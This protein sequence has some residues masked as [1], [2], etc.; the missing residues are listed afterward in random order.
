MN[1]IYF[2]QFNYSLNNHCRPVPLHYCSICVEIVSFSRHKKKT[3]MKKHVRFD[4]SAESVEADYEYVSDDD[5]DRNDDN[6]QNF[7]YPEPMSTTN[8][9]NTDCTMINSH[10]DYQDQ[11]SKNAKNDVKPISQRSRNTRSRDIT[12]FRKRRDLIEDLHKSRSRR[13]TL[14]RDLHGLMTR[15]TCKLEL[16]SAFNIVVVKDEESKRIVEKSRLF[17]Q[18]VHV[19]EAIRR[20]VESSSEVAS[21]GINDIKAIMD[22]IESD[23]LLV[24]ESQRG[25]FAQ[26]LAEEKRLNQEL[27]VIQ[28]RLSLWDR[29]G[30]L[31]E[32]GQSTKSQ[33]IDGSLTTAT[34]KESDV[35]AEIAAFQDYLVKHGGYYGGWDDLSHH[36][37]LKLRLKHGAKDE[38]FL[39]ACISTIPGIGLNEAA[40][41]EAW[42]KKF[43]LL[44]DAKKSALQ[45]W[46]ERKEAKAGM[47][48]QEIQENQM[49]HSIINQNRNEMEMQDRL[50]KKL[51]VEKWKEE[52]KTK[53]K[54]EEIKQSEIKGKLLDLEEKKR[55]RIHETIKEQ[56]AVFVRQ[57]NEHA[58]MQKMLIEET[59]R[60][61]MKVQLSTSREELMRMK[62]KNEDFLSKKKAILHA[63]IESA[64][65]KEER[66]EKLRSTV[67]V[68]VRHDPNRVYRATIGY[69]AR[70]SSPKDE[71]S[72]NSFT[73]S[74]IPKRHI[75]TWRRGL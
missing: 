48:E 8:N 36:A 33:N 54:E 31:A 71:F 13:A 43:I 55:R 37:F 40:A 4:S 11:H 6:C 46:R 22:T 32:E 28:E 72:G 2:D 3:N 39:A 58:E 47:R 68:N 7:N 5:D 15:A 42:Y 26:L 61:K 67:H 1:D 12:I 23:I 64:I 21:V 18:V 16:N 60:I 19:K 56:V 73:M 63:K 49:I 44:Q 59:E 34:G 25:N 53:K 69:I 20:L 9:T 50:A 35:P 66:L 41:H 70:I 27:S 29:P 45:R 30:G 38:K 17:G 65:Q 74:S 24:K 52:Q 62:K 51:L 14:E 75:P 10:N 57:R